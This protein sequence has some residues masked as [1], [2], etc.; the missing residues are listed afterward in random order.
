MRPI[1]ISDLVPFCVF[2]GNFNADPHRL[3]AKISFF[4]ADRPTRPMSITDL[5][6]A[7]EEFWETVKEGG[8]GKT[9]DDRSIAGFRKKRY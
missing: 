1:T 2:S 9:G 3:S 8:Y 4:N 6:K 5:D 7:T